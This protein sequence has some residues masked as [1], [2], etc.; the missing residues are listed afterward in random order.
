MSKYDNYD[1]SMCWDQGEEF[2]EFLKKENGDVVKALRKWGRDF[3]WR[4]ERCLDFADRIEKHIEKNP[5]SI[6]T[7]EG[8]KNMITVDGPKNFLDKLC[9]DAIL[10]KMELND[11]E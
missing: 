11:G 2:N 1:F 10:I 9:D 4:I 6:I 8:Y 7:I 3:S 5:E